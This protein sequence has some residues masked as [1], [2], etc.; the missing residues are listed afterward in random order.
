MGADVGTLQICGVTSPPSRYYAGITPLDRSG[1]SF[2]TPNMEIDV[3]GPV[4]V[5]GSDAR[6][7]HRDRVILSALALEPG[8]VL[9]PDR[10]ADALW[11]EMPPK[12][13]PKVVQG[14]VRRQVCAARDLNPEPAD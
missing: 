1:T 14:I 3:L 12:S 9:S 8:E 2:D 6:L 5:A 4:R 11:G 7:S 10:L 13:W